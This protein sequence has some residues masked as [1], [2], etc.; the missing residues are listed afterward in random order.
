MKFWRDW[1]MMRKCADCPFASKGAGLHLRKS[2][3]P[4]RWKQILKSLLNGKPF[5]CHKTTKETGNGSPRI[6]AG[7]IEWA[8]K[9]GIECTLVQVMSR[10]TTK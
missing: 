2:L 6:C 1:R 10:L 5:S 3:A 8:A 4:G 7:A 9:R